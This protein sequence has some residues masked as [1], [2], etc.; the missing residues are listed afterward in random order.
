MKAEIHPAYEATNVTCS[1][2]AAFVTRSTVSSGAIHVDVCSVCHPFYTGK[3]RI[4]DTG[5]RVAKFEERF[6]KK[7]K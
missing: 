7:A 2:G 3:Q 1:C 6:N 5:G 4:L